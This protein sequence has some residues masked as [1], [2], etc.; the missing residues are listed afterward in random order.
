[1]SF[2]LIKTQETRQS[3]D[4]PYRSENDTLSLHSNALLGSVIIIAIF[5]Y[6][7]NRSI[8]MANFHLKYLI[9]NSLFTIT[10]PPQSQLFRVQ[11]EV[12]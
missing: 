2:G 8:V 5:I 1:M 11:F 9:K 7:T 12:S 3:A 10:G 6:G 4:V